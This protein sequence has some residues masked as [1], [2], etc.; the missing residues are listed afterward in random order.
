[1]PSSA[2]HF[3]YGSLF[4]FILCGFMAIGFFLIH[5]RIIKD[6]LE[7]NDDLQNIF[8]N[9]PISQTINVVVD[10]KGKF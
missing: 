9:F 2:E 6:Q 5:D 10:G 3:L 7:I 8:E 4:S 1:M